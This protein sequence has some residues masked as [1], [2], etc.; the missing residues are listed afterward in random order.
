MSNRIMKKAKLGKAIESVEAAYLEL[1]D[2]YPE[3]KR[4]E[5]NSRCDS[6]ISELLRLKEEL[7]HID[8]H[9]NEVL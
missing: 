6:I 1:W 7:N 5:L 3:D 9:L 4:K 8:E 2:T